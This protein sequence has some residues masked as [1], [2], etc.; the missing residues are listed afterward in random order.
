V[1]GTLE[2]LATHPWPAPPRKQQN[3]FWSVS[4]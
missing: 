1:I 3:L 2:H 4:R